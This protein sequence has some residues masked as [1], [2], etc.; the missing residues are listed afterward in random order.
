[1]CLITGYLL[2]PQQ[3]FVP[4][5]KALLGDAGVK[6][7]H[8]RP[9]PD[10]AH[11]M[12]AQPQLLFIDLDFVDSDHAD[13]IR[14]LRSVLRDTLICVYVGVGNGKN[15]L[16]EAAGADC[17]LPKS[18]DEPQLRRLLRRALRRRANC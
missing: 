11:I 17:V 5:L 13:L 8:V 7:D 14:V 4:Y 12:Y 18:A 2:E 10:L 16:L 3:L 9:T 6:V 1:M 15:K